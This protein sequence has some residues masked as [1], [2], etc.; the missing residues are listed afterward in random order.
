MFRNDSL[1]RQQA[2]CK[3]MFLFAGFAALLAVAS[4]ET[5]AGHFNFLVIG[6]WG[7]QT[8]SPY[9]TKGAFCDPAN[10]RKVALA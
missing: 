5:A 7:G 9:A 10:S 1:L 3:T 8:G 2:F 4:S 6:D